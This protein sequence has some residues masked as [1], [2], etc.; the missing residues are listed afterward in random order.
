MPVISENLDYAVCAA[1]RRVGLAARKSRATNGYRLVNPE[2]NWIVA[3]ESFE[4]SAEDVVQLC[5]DLEAADRS[6]R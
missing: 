3:G 2:R 1:A 4:L 5:N 6:L